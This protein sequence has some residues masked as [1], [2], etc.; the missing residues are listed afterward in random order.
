LADLGSSS[1][2]IH[3][4]EHARVAGLT[5]FAEMTQGSSVE[6]VKLPT[7]RLVGSIRNTLHWCG[8]H[9]RKLRR[10]RSSVKV[11]ASDTTDTGTPE[12]ILAPYEKDK[13]DFVRCVC[14]PNHR[15]LILPLRPRNGRE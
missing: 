13:K 2:F 6:S 1:S 9:S 14:P 4:G 3:A 12:P 8:G 10:F 11:D 5:I 15:E 7:N